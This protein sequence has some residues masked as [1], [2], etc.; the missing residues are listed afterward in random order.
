M[1]PQKHDLRVMQEPARGST[2]EF[3]LFV[4]RPSQ[5]LDHRLCRAQQDLKDGKQ[6][7]AILK[8]SSTAEIQ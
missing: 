2:V 5:P 3:P 7:Q 6:C 1:L 4:S 8:D